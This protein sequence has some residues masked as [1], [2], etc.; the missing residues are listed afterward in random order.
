LL[1]MQRGRF[2]EAVEPLQRV[3]SIRGGDV[4]TRAT[5]IEA[6]LKAGMKGEGEGEIDQLLTA[7]VATKQEE[8][9]LAKLLAADREG[10]AAAEIL[11]HT[12]AIWPDCAEAHGELGLLLIQSEQYE[13]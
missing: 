9:S 12:T 13:T 3:K 7:H 6:Y 2:R 10:E 5:L 1:L 8:V 4:S 11:R